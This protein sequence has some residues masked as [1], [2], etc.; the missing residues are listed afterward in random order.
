LADA[1]QHWTGDELARYRAAVIGMDDTVARSKSPLYQEAPAPK[2]VDTQRPPARRGRAWLT[3]LLLLAA[4]AGVWKYTQERGG[5]ER[6]RRPAAPQA[7]RTAIA[8]TGDIPIVLNEL[9]TVTSLATVTVRTQIAGQ[10]QQIGFTEGEI[11]KAGDFLAQV[12]PRPYQVALEQAQGQLAKD[13]ALLAQAQSDL[14]RFQILNKQDSISRQQVEDQ[15]FLVHQDQGAVTTDQAQIDS[16]KLNITYCRIVSPVT[17]RIG[18]RQVDQ[19]NYVQVS[20]PNGIVVVTE[21]E[22]ISVIFTIPED[23][24]PSVMKRLKAGA[25]LPVTIFDRSNSKQLAT[26]TLATMDNQVDTTTGTVKLRAFFANKDDVLFPN[27]FVNASLLVDTDSGVVVV[28]NAAIQQGAPGNFVYV[29]TDK[30]SVSVRTVKIGPSDGVRTAIRSG[31]SAGDE[32]V[33]DGTDRLRD[34]ASIVVQNDDEPGKPATGQAEKPAE[35][36][37]PR[38]HGHQHHDAGDR[39]Q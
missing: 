16:A 33:I 19:G 32:V 17:G 24:I 13:Q 15:Q 7:V 11:V 8:A 5:G 14:A 39:S 18:L 28:P 9:G 34:G 29:V 38:A 31:L 10:L 27:Q 3:L 37:A 2:E 12:D 21:I 36:P 26:G 30:T 1:P 6:G 20:D 23:E 35:P 22:P 25:T 4:G